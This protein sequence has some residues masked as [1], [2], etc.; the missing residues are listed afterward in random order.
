MGVFLIG[1]LAAMVFPLIS[2]SFNNINRIRNRDEMNYIG[3]MVVEK[4]KSRQGPVR[5]FINELESADEVDYI[6]DDFDQDKYY[7]KLIKKYSSERFMEF[8]VHVELK[9][10]SEYVLYEASFSK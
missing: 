10:G 4:I 5:G 6:D 2:F 8:L 1:I 9:D 7:C 3:E